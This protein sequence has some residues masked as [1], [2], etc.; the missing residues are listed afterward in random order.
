MDTNE[1]IR[2]RIVINLDSSPGGGGGKYGGYAP[3]G[4]AQQ[5]RK[6]RR[7]PKV[8]AILGLLL[9]LGVVA[10]LAGAYFGWRHYKTT[11]SYSLALIIDAAQR[12]D[13]PAFQKQFDEDAIAKN[14]ITEVTQKASVRYG[15]A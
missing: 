15:V 8:L 10:T 1:P 14:L 3:G 11:P 2:K 9:L 6:T 5:P 12:N 4:Y 13:M 7:W